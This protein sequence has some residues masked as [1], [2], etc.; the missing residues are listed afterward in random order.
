MAQLCFKLKP[1]ISSVCKI[2]SR[3]YCTTLCKYK[4]LRKTKI[5]LN[6]LVAMA[7]TAQHYIIVA[8]PTSKFQGNGIL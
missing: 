1:I 5:S 3:K 6:I 4:G 8:M 7:T 2:W